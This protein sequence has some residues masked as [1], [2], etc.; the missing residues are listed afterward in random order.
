MRFEWDEK[1][2]ANNL[3]K[4]RVSFAEA[5]TVFEDP[6]AMTFDDPDH[7]RRESRFVTIGASRFDRLLFV[8]HADRSGRIRIISARRATRR[9]S[10]D[11]E[12]AWI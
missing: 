6:N 12:E 4:H 3:R 2:A 5:A 7:S 10:H 11:Y 9:E 1:K 8:A